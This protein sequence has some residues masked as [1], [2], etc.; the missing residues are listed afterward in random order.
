[1]HSNN[2]TPEVAKIYKILRSKVREAREAGKNARIG[3]GSIQIDN[4]WY[5]LNPQ[6][7]QLVEQRTDPRGNQVDLQKND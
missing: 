5:L 1:M 7:G 6:T 2:R 3:N 4:I